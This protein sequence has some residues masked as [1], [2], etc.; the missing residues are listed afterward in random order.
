M[1]RGVRRSLCGRLWFTL[2]LLLLAGRV[3]AAPEL[4]LRVTGTGFG[5]RATWVVATASVEDFYRGVFLERWRVEGDGLHRLAFSGPHERVFLWLLEDQAGDGPSAADPHF[6][7]S[8]T[9]EQPRADGS[10]RATFSLAVP[11]IALANQGRLWWSHMLDWRAGAWAAGAALLMLSMLAL[12]LWRLGRALDARVATVLLEGD[13]S[14]SVADAV[15]VNTATSGTW[16]Y[17]DIVSGFMKLAVEHYFTP[18]HMLANAELCETILG[19]DEFQEAML[20]D[21][22]K[23]GNLPT[24]LGMRLV[25]MEDQA[26]NKL[27]I[28]DAGYA[29]QKLTEQDLL[30]ESDKLIN[31]QWDRTYLTVVTDFA[32]IYAKARVVVNSDWS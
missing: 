26:A 8:L 6:L 4:A 17:G 5:G 1:S 7:H 27:T 13:G 30:V 3:Q 25:P 11:P 16:A 15:T 31:Q 14:G 22:A 29:V 12:W 32:I 23:T 28:L 9:P 24:P 20:F 19:L 10:Y 2:A 18:T 21:F